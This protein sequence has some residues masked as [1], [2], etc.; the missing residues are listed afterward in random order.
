VDSFWSDARRGAATQFGRVH[1]RW[2]VAVRVLPA[3]L[4]LTVAGALLAGGWWA[5]RAL[6]R[7]DAPGWPSGGTQVLIAGGVLLAL[8]LVVRRLRRGYSVPRRPF[9]RY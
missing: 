6:I 8:V 5:V 9:R 7:L 2:W 3:V 4:G 1:Y